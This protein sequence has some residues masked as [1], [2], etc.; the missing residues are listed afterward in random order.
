MNCRELAELLLDF[1]D[2]ELTEEFRA[3]V[4]HHLAECPPCVIYME[5]Y[6]ITVTLSRQLSTPPLPEALAQRLQTLLR[7]CEQQAGQGQDGKG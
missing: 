6:Q 5:T 3:R 2:G 1:L 4:C 7:Q